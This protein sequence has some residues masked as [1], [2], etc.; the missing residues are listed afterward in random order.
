MA[1]RFVLPTQIGQSGKVL[2]TDGTNPYWSDSTGA[3]TYRGVLDASGG[4][5]PTSPAKGDYYIISVAGTISGIVYNIGDW[6]V[7]N[8]T[9]WDKIDNTEAIFLTVENKT[10]TYDI[11]VGDSEKV[12]TMNSGSAK[13]F[14]LPVI[15]SGDIGMKITL[16]KKGAGRV[17]IQ[18]NSGQYIDDST[19]AGTI[20]DDQAA[21]LTSTI[22]LLAISTTQWVIVS[23]NGIWITT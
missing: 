8:G 20:Y 12:L 15:S 2:K 7:Y 21:E 4:V 17:T 9:T 13:V 10:D 22:T 11:V 18:A 5:Y 1:R 6:A 19:S 16:I 3:I 23:A 14:N